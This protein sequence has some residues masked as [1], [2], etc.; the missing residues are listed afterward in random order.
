[1]AG[2]KLLQSISPKCTSSKKF[3]NSKL[4]V[5]SPDLSVSKKFFG[6]LRRFGRRKKSQRV[7]NFETTLAQ[8]VEVKKCVEKPVTYYDIDTFNDYYEVKWNSVYVSSQEVDNLTDSDGDDQLEYDDD[9]E[10]ESEETKKG[11]IYDAHDLDDPCLLEDSSSNLC[12]KH[13]RLTASLGKILGGSGKSKSVGGLAGLVRRSA[14]FNRPCDKCKAEETLAFEEA[15]DIVP[16][17]L[18]N[19]IA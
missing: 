12:K 15:T 11:L 4:T 5:K 18:P 1:M 17:K 3:S 13:H 8:D 9:C 6:R 2:L 16:V 7:R 10:T 19:C 14:W